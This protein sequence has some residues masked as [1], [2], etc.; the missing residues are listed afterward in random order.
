MSESV[1]TSLHEEGRP[2]RAEIAASW[3]RSAMCG[4]DP[5]AAAESRLIVDVDVSGRLPQASSQILD[6]LAEQVDGERF[7]VNA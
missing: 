7:S 6:R 2:R 3:Y 1:P 5:T 4:L